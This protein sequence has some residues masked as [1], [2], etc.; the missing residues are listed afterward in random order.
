MAK[1]KEST[2]VENEQPE[3]NLPENKVDVADAGTLKKKVT[4]TVPRAKIDAKMD[5]MY[6]E[7]SHSAQIP[8]F[9]IGRAP[10]RLIEKRFGKDVSADVRNSLIGES[11]GDAIEKSELNTLGEPDLD[12]EKIEMPDTG[13]MSFDFEVEVSPEFDMPECKGIKVEK[14]KAVV[15]DA[16]VDE[17][18]EQW[19]T[20]QATFEATEDAAAESDVIVANAKLS[21]DGIDVGRNELT[22]RVAPGQIEGIPLVELGNTLSGKK[23]GDAAEVSIKVPDT[24]PN[25]DWRGKDVKIALEITQVRQR[26][27]PELD[28]TFASAIGMGSMEE[29]RKQVAGSLEARIEAETQRAMRDQI[30]KYLIDNTKFDLPEGVVKRHTAQVLQ[31]RYMDLM[32]RGM[33]RETI[34]ENLTKLQAAATEQATADLKLSFILAKVAQAE[35]IEV[36]G[37]E[38]NSRIA[39]MAQQYQRR[40]ER[41]RQEL[42][43][44]GSI[45]QLETMIQEEKSLDKLLEDAKITEVEPKKAEPAAEKKTAKKAKKKAKA[46]KSDDDKKKAAPKVAKKSAKKT[47]KKAAKKTAKKAAKKSDK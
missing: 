28:D 5:E 17:Q 38:M 19:R 11:I 20:M 18:L 21:G 35:K 30:C 15:D 27:L 45:S 22:L 44:D 36:T 12:L 7:L 4:V 41:L 8:G 9:R 3:S 10:R 23:A 37:E 43:S 24:H 46:A 39:S 2:Q 34:D 40:P 26:K 47:A 33:P 16:R 42:E 1:E 31:R 25:E 6:G 32:Q 13:D 14:E 29:L